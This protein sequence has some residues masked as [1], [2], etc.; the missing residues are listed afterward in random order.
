M[1]EVLKS[2]RSGHFKNSLKQKVDWANATYVSMLNNSVSP[3]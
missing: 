1:L 2:A 3:P